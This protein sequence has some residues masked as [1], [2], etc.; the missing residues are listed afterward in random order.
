MTTISSENAAQALARIIER[1]GRI[2]SKVIVDSGT[3]FFSVPFRDFIQSLGAS[4]YHVGGSSWVAERYIRTLKRKLFF[5]MLRYRNMDWVSFLQNAVRSINRS[6]NRVIRTTPSSVTVRDEYAIFRRLFRG[7]L[8]PKSF[9]AKYDLK[10]FV[11]LTT[12]SKS[13]FMKQSRIYTGNAT[14]EIFLI[15][16][17]RHSPSKGAKVLY[18]LMDLG[19]QV[20]QSNFYE[21]ELIKVPLKDVDGRRFVAVLGWEFEGASGKNKRKVIEKRRSGSKVRVK[22]FLL[23][24]SKGDDFLSNFTFRGG[25][26]GEEVPAVSIAY[27][28]DEEEEE[29]HEEVRST[30]RFSV[31]RDSNDRVI[32]ATPD[33]VYQLSKF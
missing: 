28:D 30:E 26:G 11:K 32:E 1:S 24:Q 10:T 3:E 31:D 27:S 4:Y 18:T 6:V 14:E 13:P 9:R 29:D 16:E 23:Y 2:M 17:L 7:V 8:P 5:Y 25:G 15:R 33:I 19:C 12:H 21:E 22:F 20:I